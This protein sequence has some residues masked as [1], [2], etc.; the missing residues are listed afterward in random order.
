M[1]SSSYSRPTVSLPIPTDPDSLRI[2]KN[3]RERGMWSVDVLF[4]QVTTDLHTLSIPTKSTSEML[5]NIPSRYKTP[6]N[7]SLSLSPCL[8]FLPIIFNPTHPD[9]PDLPL[10]PFCLFG[11]AYSSE[12]TSSSP[13]PGENSALLPPPALVLLSDK[14][15][16]QVCR[17][18]DGYQICYVS[19]LLV[20]TALCWLQPLV[21]YFTT[22][23]RGCG[24][25]GRRQVKGLIAATA[26][27]NECLQ[28]PGSVRPP[29]SA[30][31][32]P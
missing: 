20:F 1:P 21:V 32:V 26:T 12:M 2:I 30:T 23:R 31:D 28:E 10:F 14:W 7:L 6:N 4:V 25:T 15:L 22:D 27:F 13:L 17:S 29:A 3:M 9:T 16:I 8:L 19:L 5:M 24:E 11:R 18:T